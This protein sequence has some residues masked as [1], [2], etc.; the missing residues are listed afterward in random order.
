MQQAW[1]ELEWQQKVVYMQ[2]DGE[3]SATFYQTSGPISLD[4]WYG[5]ND[6]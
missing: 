3:G 1:M 2:F 4:V 5:D 6:A